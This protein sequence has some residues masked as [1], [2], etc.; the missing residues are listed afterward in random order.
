MSSPK[1]APITAQVDVKEVQKINHTE[2]FDAETLRD[3][4][5]IRRGTT[6]PISLKTS[7]DISIGHIDTAKLVN[8]KFRS[9]SVP[10]E[11]V[12]PNIKSDGADF[13]VSEFIIS[14]GKAY[15]M[16]SIFKCTH[17]HT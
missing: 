5:I 11:I 3:L 13:K 14:A 17:I 7:G 15:K 1:P 8:S 16:F 4:L 12:S 9:L 10:L 6:F 2:K